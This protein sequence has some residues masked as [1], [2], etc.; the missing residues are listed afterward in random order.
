MITFVAINLFLVSLYLMKVILTFENYYLSWGELF[1]IKII[2]LTL[3]IMTWI[4]LF[5]IVR[6][7]P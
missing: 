1:M 2:P 3:I 4:S 7:L 6:I 5:H